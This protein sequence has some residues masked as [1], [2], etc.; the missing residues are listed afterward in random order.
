MPELWTSV[1]FFKAMTLKWLTVANW[2]QPNGDDWLECINLWVYQTKVVNPEASA[3]KRMEDL[4]QAL[5]EYDI[6]KY[7]LGCGIYEPKNIS[8]TSH[9]QWQWGV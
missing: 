5:L 9:D 8:F 2:N 4:V 7:Y 3:A 1:T 6:I